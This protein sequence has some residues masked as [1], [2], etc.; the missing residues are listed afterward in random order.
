MYLL[1]VFL[2][3]LGF[4][5][6]LSFGRFFGKYFSSIVAVSTMGFSFL[7]SLF[8][9]YE[10]VLS[11]S[12]CQINLGLWVPLQVSN[13]YWIF[14]YDTVVVLMLNLVLLV[15]FLVHIYSLEYMSMTLFLLDL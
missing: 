2:P 12:F 14:L 8:L 5:T 7:L 1:I 11:G 3:I 13:V 9:Y 10:V 4:F 6:L 15:S